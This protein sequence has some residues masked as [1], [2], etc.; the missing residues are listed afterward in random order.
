MN[1]VYISKTVELQE[2]PSPWI[3]CVGSSRLARII[4]YVANKWQCLRYG[5][6]MLPMNRDCSRCGTQ[7]P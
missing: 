7:C 1:K 5:H 6:W 2:F 4:A 3:V